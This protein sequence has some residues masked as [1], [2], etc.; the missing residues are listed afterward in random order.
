MSAPAAPWRA[1]GDGAVLL[2]VR[3][4]P[5][6]SAD[7]IGPLAKDGSGQ[8]R[9]KAKVRAVPEDGKAN[10]SL[11]ALVAKSLKVP[12]S[13]VSIEA[14]HASHSKTLRIDGEAGTLSALLDA[15]GRD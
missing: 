5:K 14:G 2:F 15:I 7:R 3:L 6:A 13:A 9:L 12:K 4:T 8:M 11:I 1:T 10:A